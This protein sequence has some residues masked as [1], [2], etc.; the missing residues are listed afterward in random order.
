MVSFIL[1]GPVT[2][3]TLDRVVTWCTAPTG[4]SAGIWMSGGGISEDEDGN[5]YACTGN[6]QVGDLGI[7][8]LTNRGESIVKIT[9][10]DSTLVVS[11]FFTPYNWLYLN[12]VDADLGTC[13]VMLIPGTD[14]ALTAGKEGILYVA[15]KDSMGGVDSVDHV[16]QKINVN[17]L[18]SGGTVY[19]SSDSGDYVY[20]WPSFEQ[21]LYRYTVDHTTG[22]LDTTTLM[23]S[24]MTE[25]FIPGGILS[26]SANGSQAGT[27]ILWANVPLDWATVGVPYRPSVLRAFD[28]NDITHEL[29]NSQQ[30]AE[31]D[32]IAMYPK[33]VP[34]TIAN[35]K[36]YMATFAGKVFMYGIFDP[37]GVDD[38]NAGLPELVAYPNPFIRTLTIN[39]QSGGALHISITNL[40]GQC[41]L[42]KDVSGNEKITLNLDFLVEGI[43]FVTVKSNDN[44]NTIRVV[45]DK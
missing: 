32:S 6:G 4:W 8:S 12:D 42:E 41:V 33:F 26:L 36:V 17:T 43:Y 38:I 37:D 1:H 10:A 9:R 45:K 19:W 16:R 2:A 13:A 14:M 29:W 40:P 28:A 23:Q 27:G 22:T 5:L 11:S 15:D 7:D 25:D 3:Q 44:V 21:P 34:P 35:G 20:I 18:C 30:N 24:T 39:P 31:R